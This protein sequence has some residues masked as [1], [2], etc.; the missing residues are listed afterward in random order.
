[1]G[2]C[3]LAPVMMIDNE[4]FGKMTPDRVEQVLSKYRDTASVTAEASN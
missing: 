2:T 3:S 1:L 4:Y